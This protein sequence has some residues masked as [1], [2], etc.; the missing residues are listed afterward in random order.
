[1]HLYERALTEDRS[2]LELTRHGR[3]TGPAL[4]DHNGTPAAPLTHLSRKADPITVEL[5]NN[6]MAL[7]HD[8]DRFSCTGARRLLLSECPREILP[9]GGEGEESL[10][11]TGEIS[12]SEAA[13]E[14]PRPTHFQVGLGTTRPHNK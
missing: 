11:R 6:R 12:A 2:S 1:M 8:L 5:A 14:A 3:V 13:R 10:D 4:K 7:G 9:V